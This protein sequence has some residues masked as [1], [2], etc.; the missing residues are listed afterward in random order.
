MSMGTIGSSRCKCAERQCSIV[1]QS[2][3]QGGQ[4]SLSSF[5]LTCCRSSNVVLVLDPFVA[6]I[7]VKGI[8]DNGGHAAPG[9]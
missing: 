8:H 5:C 9:G 2:Q 7:A 3:L 6:G 1:L 4:D